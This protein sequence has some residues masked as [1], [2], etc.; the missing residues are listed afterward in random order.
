MGGGYG[1]MNT[2]INNMGG[3][4]NNNPMGGMGGGYNT[5]A[6]MGGGYNTNAN[7]GGYGM[8]M[9][10]NNPT[11]GFNNNMNMGGYG[12]ANTFNPPPISGGFNSGLPSSNAPKKDAFDDLD[13]FSITT[14]S[15][16][17]PVQ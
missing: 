13:E 5:N 1:G 16:K 14:T 7:M 9:N 8:G 17:P 11:G 3:N 15:T 10:N 2:G 4:M 6:N 12:G